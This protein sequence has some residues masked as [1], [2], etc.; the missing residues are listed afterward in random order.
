MAEM[1]VNIAKYDE[2]EKRL[3][4]DIHDKFGFCYKL[5]ARAK[6]KQKFSTRHYASKTYGR[7]NK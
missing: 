2:L 1:T 6:W 7:W 5:V 4:K 3:Q